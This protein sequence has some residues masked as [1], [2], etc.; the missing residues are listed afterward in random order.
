MAVTAPRTYFGIHSIQAYRLSDRTPY[1]P[2]IKVLGGMN[3]NIS[4]EFVDLN[5]GSSKFILA[6]EVGTFTP[7]MTI[8]AR[9]FRN[10]M[11]ET[12]LGATTSEVAAEAAGQVSTL[13]NYNGTSAVDAA[14]GMASIAAKASEEGDLKFGKYTI[15]VKSATEI[16][17]TNS[18]DIDNKRG[19]DIERQNDDLELYAA[20]ITIPGTGGTVDLPGLGLTITGGSG[21]IAMT[22]GDTAVFEV[23]P[24]NNGSSTIRVGSVDTVI[25]EVGLF[26][27]GQKKG[28]GEMVEIEIFRCQMAGLPH[29]FAEKA[30]AEAEIQV[31]PLVDFTEDAVMEIRTLK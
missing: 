14:T 16:N 11:Y 27:Y 31:K 30:W 12:C 6:T 20:D 9:E 4:P 3:L 17:V 24:I 13:E 28:N 8:T 1:G 18:S 25:P 5:G 15:I 22:I 2:E 19:T 29:N 26:A 10:W 23:R 21:A 7:E